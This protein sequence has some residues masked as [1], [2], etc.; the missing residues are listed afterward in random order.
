MWSPTRLNHSGDITS[1]GEAPPCPGD[2]SR[3]SAAFPPRALAGSAQ[4]SCTAT[5][6]GARRELCQLGCCRFSL[7][8]TK[9]DWFS[10]R[11][12]LGAAVLIPKPATFHFPATVA[13]I[14]SRT[15][16]VRI[17]AAV[18][19]SLLFTDPSGG[20]SLCRV[21]SLLDRSESA[22]FAGSDLPEN[23]SKPG[24]GLESGFP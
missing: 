7:H 10:A 4:R 11:K 20:A 9:Q 5:E 8:G 15:A 12:M 17:P 19:K 16:L 23:Y 13:H 21:P 18:V 6:D 14:C 24:F 22:G 2:I 3:S 1:P